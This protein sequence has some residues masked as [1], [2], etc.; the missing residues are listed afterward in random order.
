MTVQEFEEIYT[1]MRGRLVGIARV[2]CKS[3]SLDLDAEDVVQEA[4]TVFWELSERGYPIK[5]PNALLVKITKNICISRYR[6]R[7][8]VTEPLEIDN[9]TG[10]VS[11]SQGVERMDEQLLKQRLYGCLS[12]MERDYMI[13]K[14]SQ[15]L[16]LDEI[17]ELTGKP[18][19]GIKTALSKAKRRLKEELK[20]YERYE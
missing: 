12:N 11:A 9:F 10:G 3:T 1:S 20:K 18:K 14:T 16:S 19:P 4:L 13:M 17:A 15:G 7:R 5:N 6:K 2:F 8:V